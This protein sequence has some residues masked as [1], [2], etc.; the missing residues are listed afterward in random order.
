MKAIEDNRFDPI[1]TEIEDEEEFLAIEA[2]QRLEV[3]PGLIKQIM[4]GNLIECPKSTCTF[5]SKRP[6][7]I[8]KHVKGHRDCPLC[9]KSSYGAMNPSRWLKQHFRKEHKKAIKCQ[10]CQRDDFKFLSHLQNH[11]VNC[12]K[13]YEAKEKVRQWVSDRQ[14]KRCLI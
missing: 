11:K 14:I 9:G 1:S 5:N 6:S 12:S 2:R 7:T 10:F 4:D 3:L 13:K 8:L